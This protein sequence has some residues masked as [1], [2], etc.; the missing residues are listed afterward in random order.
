[1]ISDSL[2]KDIAVYLSAADELWF[3]LALIKDNAFEHIK[4]LVKE[5]CKQHYLVGIDLPTT[6]TVLK[7][8]QSTLEP[9]LVEC[10]IYKNQFNYH[11][12]VYLFKSNGLFTAFIGSSNLTDGG[13]EKNV[14]L[15]YK[16][17]NQNDCLSILT[18]FNDLYKEGFPLT[19]ENI[20]EYQEQVQA[21][22]EPE[23]KLKQRRKAIKLRKP[24]S[25]QNP[26]DYIDFSDRFFKKEHHLAFRKELW[27]SDSEEAIAERELTK[28]KCIELHKTIFHQFKDY[29]IQI[30]EPNP[31]PDHLI[32]MIRQ[33][34][35]TK[36]R[37]IDAMWLSY[38]KN[39]NEIKK[40]QKEVGPDQKAK[41]T[42][43]HHARLQI[44][45]DIE[46]IGIWL[47]F[48]K[49]NEGGIFDRAFFKERM[50]DT[51]YRD[52]LFQM[53]KSL[54]EEYFISVGGKRLLCSKFSS[55]A[56]LHDFCKNDNL[57][58]YFIIG[59]DY[60]ISDSQMLE[61][62]LP[63]ETLEVFKLLFPFYETMRHRILN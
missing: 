55:S 54:P 31:M 60:K 25:N 50:R 7:T 49:E 35:P 63:S 40:Y 17:T 43:I 22:H 39:G 5:N 28:E 33:I 41:Q 16:V 45:I 57:Q 11:P 21:I 20:H 1:M 6:P 27:Y 36:P 23:E 62:N 26:L 2:K 51:G 53:L 48:A 34:D 42:F 9:G 56:D 61:I 15:N 46:N 19:E 14:E 24:P 18:W 3:A 44:R 38:G 13:L 30:L 10:K 59:K 47:L 32:S 58:Q 4:S 12:K 37:A 8:I 52:K 29:G